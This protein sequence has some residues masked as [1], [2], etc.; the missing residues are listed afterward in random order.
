VTAA[1]EIGPGQIR[2]L[3]RRLPAAPDP[4]ALY[5]ALSDGAERA[6]TCLLESA[7]RSTHD[8]ERSLIGAR[9]AVHLTADLERVR[10]EAL[11]PNGRA[12]LGWLRSELE[13]RG[14]PLAD[15][16]ETRQPRRL[17]IV[18]PRDPRACVDERARFR[19]PSP[20][21]VL[22]LLQRGPRLVARPNAWCHVL[23]GVLGYDLID[24]FEALPFGR[25][26]PLEQP[27]T[28]WWLPEELVVIDHVRRQ[29]TVV[30]AV[31][32]GGEM[33][34][35][36][37][38]GGNREHSLTRYHDAARAL[39]RL[40]SAVEATAPGGAPVPAAGSLAPVEPDVATDP[41]DATYAGVVA[42]LQEHLRAG[43]AYQVVP[44]R[45]FRLACPDP[46]GAYER[47][48]RANPSPYLFFLRGESR[49][50][51]GASP[52]TCLRVDG[53]TRQVSV[54]PIAG[55]AAR[56]R[57]ALGRLDPDAD[58]R[59]EVA[60]RLDIKEAAEHLMLVDL[61]R[62]DVARV[63]EPGSRAVTR[64][65]AVERYAHVMHLVS[66]VRGTLRPDLDAL[67]AYAATMNMGTL[68][69]APKVRAAALLREL[70]PS[71]RGFYGGAVGYLL[72]DD[73][74]ETAIVIRSALVQ[75]GVAHVRAGAG[76]VLDSEPRRE[77]EETSRKARAVLEA[78]AAGAPAYA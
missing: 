68:V 20:L 38:T 78:I 62:N 2:P 76:V 40:V 56:G 15:R 44:S 11:S 19:Q 52:E 17:E 6:H 30:V 53:P 14:G 3:V 25:P 63:S 60:L 59:N 66:E 16:L 47:L 73:T 61:A 74:L 64:L 9:M 1:L 42:T 22:R 69:G 71:R 41:D 55:T 72:D 43:D 12:A 45:T 37:A 4:F 8:G 13:R 34:G 65:L 31:W 27:V 5:S 77:A 21:D 7:D 18:L 23:V 54:L 29:S 10:V 48:R 26:D 70:E 32:G 75:H 36:G 50:L 28:E 24:C 51:F 33:A 57:D 58:T 39:E 67:E 49:V 35:N 46:L